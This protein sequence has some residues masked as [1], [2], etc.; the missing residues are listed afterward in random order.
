MTACGAHIRSLDKIEQAIQECRNEIKTADG[1]RQ[2]A[3]EAFKNRDILMTQYVYLCAVREY[4]RKGGGSRGSYL[5]QNKT[6]TLPLES[7]PEDFRFSLDSGELLNSVCEIALDADTMECQCEWK[8]VRPIPVEDN[9]FENIWAECRK[10][11][12]IK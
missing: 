8:P 3:A 11:N 12:V 9:W 10:G 1:R 2:T 6:G 7:L 4:I 5:I